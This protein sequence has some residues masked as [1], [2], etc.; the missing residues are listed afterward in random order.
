MFGWGDFE[1][2]ASTGAQQAGAE[3]ISVKPGEFEKL[4]AEAEADTGVPDV[5]A[6]DTA[7]IL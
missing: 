6:D 5:A 2:A 3:L 1:E 4:L 7:V